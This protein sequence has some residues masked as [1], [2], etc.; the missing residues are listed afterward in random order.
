[1]YEHQFFFF[2]I[3][4][5]KILITNG[6][7]F[8]ENPTT[9]EIV[10]LTIKG[11]NKCKNW[12]DFPIAVQR[13]IGGLIGNTVLICGGHT[14][15]SH[16]V[17]A[18]Y[19]L[20]SQKATLVTHLSVARFNAASIVLSNTILWVTGG[21]NGNN[22]LA[23]TEFVSIDGSIPGPDLIIAVA[24]HAV[25]AINSTFSMV[26]G[27]IPVVCIDACSHSLSS[28]FY[29]DHNKGELCKGPSL[30]AARNNH[31]AGIVTDEVT[32]EIFV[33]VTGGRNLD[34]LDSTE[35]LQEKKWLQGMHVK[36]WKFLI[37]K[38]CQKTN[39]FALIAFT[40]SLNQFNWQKTSH[41]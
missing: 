16:D 33:V 35:I 36:H 3:T 13:P 27:G 12:P 24:K 28:T 4:V 17:E 34:Y 32:N 15:D 10:D 31:A 7:N 37:T 23:S 11:G 30:M 8:D 29:H 6:W 18:C 39:W 9:S 2:L 26:I 21:S 19:S 38:C 1:M 14:E 40:L 22:V 41:F 25:V 5:S 20:T